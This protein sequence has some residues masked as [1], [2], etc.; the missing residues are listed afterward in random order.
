MTKR[1]D[2][3]K[4]VMLPGVSRIGGIVLRGLPSIKKLRVATA[5]SFILV[6]SGALDVASIEIT[7]DGRSIAGKTNPGRAFHWPADAPRLENGSVYRVT[8]K[9]RGTPE[10]KI[11]KVEV[12]GRSGKG[13]ITLIRID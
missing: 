4:T 7:R 1:V 10:P 9:L 6:G 8:L 3:P 12:R 5:P 2:C 13:V 11:F